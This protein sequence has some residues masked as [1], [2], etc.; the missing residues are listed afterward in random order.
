METQEKLFD[1]TKPAS[2]EM[3]DEFR[4]F[5]AIP[6]RPNVELK[7]TVKAQKAPAPERSAQPFVPENFRDFPEVFDAQGHLLDE[8]IRQIALYRRATSD[9]Y[10]VNH[11]VVDSF[12]EYDRGLGAECSGHMNVHLGTCPTCQARRDSYLAAH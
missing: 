3:P 1:T 11:S 9:R 6:T 7:R 2:T 10:K 12:N 8:P 4:T 5:P